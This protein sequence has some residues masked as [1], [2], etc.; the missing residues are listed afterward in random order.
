MQKNESTYVIED[1]TGSL[2]LDLSNTRFKDGLFP[3]HC[4]VLVEGV[5]DDKVFYA[6][7]LGFPP[8]EPKLRSRDYFGNANT[9]G[10]PSE[11]SLTQSASLLKI[12]QENPH[13]MIVFLSD[14]WLDK[15]QVNF[16]LIKY[17]NSKLSI[18]NFFFPRY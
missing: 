8:A 12:Q 4:F 9:F 17:S 10:G 7:G 3:E 11:I 15:I 13:A 2:Q 14:V 6:S 18:Y 5:Y 16:F 1:L